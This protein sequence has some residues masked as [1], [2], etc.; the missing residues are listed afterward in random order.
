MSSESDTSKSAP[1]PR[2]LT[3]FVCQG[4]GCLCD[5]IEAEAVG[6]RISLLAGLCNLGGEWFETQITARAART[7]IPLDPQQI[8]AAASLLSAARFPALIGVETLTA[9]SQRLA[10]RLAERIGG[11]I[12]SDPRP[13]MIARQEV[14]EVTCTLGEIRA[15][16]D[17]VVFWF[18]DPARTHP[19]HLERYSGDCTGRFIPN[20]RADRTLI[21]VDEARTATAALADEFIELPANDEFASLEALRFRINKPDLG[22]SPPA[23]ARESA[24]I[25]KLA[26]R[27]QAAKYGVMVA[28]PSRYARS[29][30]P[31]E[32][33]FKLV[34][35]LNLH[36]CFVVSPL[37]GSGNVKGEESVL[38]W[39]TGFPANVAF[40]DGLPVYDGNAFSAE[41]LLSRGRVDAAIVFDE[42]RTLDPLLQ[43]AQIPTIKIGGDAS[44][45]AIHLPAAAPIECTGTVFR[46]DGVP[47][48]TTPLFDAKNPT[49]ERVLEML[50]DAVNK[51]TRPA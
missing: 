25:E 10:V 29:S 7:A 17:L 11:V 41:A 42:H 50:I 51:R 30:V 37:A 45:A 4:C 47:L 28:D 22:R 21:V 26:A 43:R 23:A 38:Q 34:R 39:L 13:A 32:S 24:W 46:M 1:T 6:D 2:R 27:M 15:R 5:D 12:A 44:D 18:A 3:P 36:T 49:P 40:Q 16:A 14:G 8:D 33:A 20:G 9:E 19:R 31:L 48:P 35:D